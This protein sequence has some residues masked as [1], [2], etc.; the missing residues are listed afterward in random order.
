M[1]SHHFWRKHTTDSAQFMDIVK[2]LGSQQL[3]DTILFGGD[4]LDTT[5][6]PHDRIITRYLNL[7]ETT[8][9]LHLP[10]HRFYV[11]RRSMRREVGRIADWAYGVEDTLWKLRLQAAMMKGYR[12][13]A[14][15][16]VGFGVGDLWK[17]IDTSGLRVRKIGAK[18]YENDGGITRIR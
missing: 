9:L 11:G 2:R 10:P 1:T 4:F 8:K 13:F 6:S 5:Q 3:R 14:V 16:R 12:K 15:S 7:T 18:T 17:F